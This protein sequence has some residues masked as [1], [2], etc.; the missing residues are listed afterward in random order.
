MPLHGVPDQMMAI[1]PASIQPMKWLKTSTLVMSMWGPCTMS[2]ET[3]A[4][5][6]RQTWRDRLPPPE[7]SSRKMRWWPSLASLSAA[8][9]S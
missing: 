9:S 1:M 6:K 7:N 4:R 3:T 5:P 2:T 8:R